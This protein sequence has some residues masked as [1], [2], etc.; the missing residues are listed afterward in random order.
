MKRIWFFTIVLLI[1]IKTISS[2]LNDFLNKACILPPAD[3]GRKID[4]GEFKDAGNQNKIFTK[5]GSFDR[6]CS[7]L[8][9]EGEPSSFVKN[10]WILRTEKPLSKSEI[11]SLSLKGVKVLGFIPYNCY[12]VKIV[13]P[14][15]IEEILKNDLITFSPLLKIEPSLFLTDFPVNPLISIYLDKEV[16]YKIFFKKIKEHYPETEPVSYFN[17][18]DSVLRV[19][20]EGKDLKKLLLFLAEN[21]ET[22]YVEPFFLPEP[23]NDYSV[24][25]VQSYDTD[26][27]TNYPICATIWNHG[28]TGTDETPAVCDTGLDSDMCFFRLSSDS[29]AITDAQ[30][31][32]LPNNGTIDNSK[33]VIVYNVLPGASAY[34]G[35]YTCSSGYHHGTHVCSSVFGDNYVNLSTSSSG[36]H[37]SGDGMAPNAKLIFQDAGLENT[38]CLNGLANDFQLIFKQAYDAGARIHSNS[39]GSYL[40]SIYDGDS[41]NID[42]FSYNNEDFLFFFAAGNNGASGNYTVNSPSTAKNVVSVGATSNGSSGSNSIASFSSRGPCSDGRLKPDIV[43]PGQS[44]IGASAD[45]IHNSNNCSTRSASGTS[46]ATPTAAGAATLLREYFRKGYYPSG[47]PDSSDIINPSS[48]L[49]KAALINGAVDISATSQSAILNSLYPNFNQGWGRL[50]LDTVLFFSSPIR[51]S[52]GLRVWDKVNSSGLENGN[53]DVYTLSV[54]SSSEPLKVT[55]VWT[56]PPPSP[57]SGIAL[58]HDLDLEVISPSNVVYR[59][60]CF[61]NGS[62]YSNGEK[63]YLNNVE[64]VFILNPETGTYQIKIIG[65][66]IPFISNFENSEKQG[67]A[68]VATFK[69]CGGCSLTTSNLSASNNGVNGIDLNW[70]SV[71]GAIKYQI[72]RAEGDCSSS[73]DSYKFTKETSTNNFTD[74][75]VQGGKIYSYKVRVVNSCAEGPLSNCASATYSGNCSLKPTFSG[76]ES[77]GT[78]G[79]S[80]NLSWSSG[81]SNCPNS[82]SVSYNIYRSTTPYFEPSNITLF[83]TGLTSTN[84]TDTQVIPDTTYY[85]IVRCEDSTTSNSGPNNGGNEDLNKIVKYATVYGSTYSYGTLT[86]DGGDSKALLTYQSLWEITDEMNHTPS[87]KFCYH[88]G[89]RFL[90][91]S[92]GVCASLVSNEIHLEPSSTPTLSFYCNY[93]LEYGYDGV[94]VEISNDGGV[95]YSPISPTQGYPYSF[96]FTGSPP[97]NLCGYSSTQ[98]AFSGPSQ[99]TSL[100]G[101]NYYSFDLSSYSGNSVILRWNLSSDAG[102]TY[103][104]FFLDDIAIAHAGIYDDCSNS[105]GSLLF[106]KEAYCFEETINITLYD[107]DLEGS[108][109]VS[110]SVS[111]TTET[112]PENVTLTEN[113]SNSGRFYGT[114]STTGNIP[115]SD[116]LLSISEGDTITA[117]Y[118]DSFDGVSNNVSKYS[119]ARAE[120]LPDEIAKGLSSSDI[121]YFSEDKAYQSW[122]AYSGAKNYRLYRGTYEQLPYLLDEN[123]DSCLVYEGE[124]TTAPCPENPSSLTGK[125]Y[126]YL[127]TAVNNGGEGSPGNSTNQERVVNWQLCK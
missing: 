108:G 117:L 80:I 66:Y 74:T 14:Q 57:L 78:N 36:G 10:Q 25:V 61:S 45:E 105:D 70:D 90:D 87:G 48:A 44:I 77:I 104:G 5:W 107:S 23:M 93:N 33:K 114:I 116:G 111:S 84:Y 81:T 73:A 54:T 63:D 27:K 51:E 69:D 68:L 76:I 97:Q 1:C 6:Y 35:S 42:I 127:V 56:E 126:W 75:S 89:G 71:P 94:V 60:N 59:G 125:L 106:D 29:S 8:N 38:G 7:E 121:Q 112:S 85:Y 92:N 34:D 19:F 41:R 86:D 101:F 26:N 113:P 99:N 16:D 11:S 53:E 55:L 21:E 65:S 67:Y 102:V 2:N 58:S 3:Y 79:C 50:L 30:Y 124:M 64:E 17:S 32:S 83:K 118:I 13:E 123:L 15:K 18:F 4:L 22:I 91:Y 119:K 88:S 37:D 109:S 43:A 96:A 120:C 72:F 49:I 40:G 12:L 115:S 47:Q 95:N 122:P 31:P 62:S 98:G 46:M 52:R 82:P 24:Y 9:L 103:R 20:Y 110:V 39:Y 100:S 28:I